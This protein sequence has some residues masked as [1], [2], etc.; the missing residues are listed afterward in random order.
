MRRFSLFSRSAVSAHHRRMPALSLVM[1]ARNEAR[2]IERCLNSVRE[3]VDSMFVLDTGS[4]DGTPEIA[5]RAGARVES[6]TWCDDFSAARNAALQRA[7][8][9]WALVL[10]ADEWLVAGAPALLALRGE[11]PLSIGVLRVDNLFGADAAQAAHSPSWLSRVLPRGVRYEGRIHEQPAADWP[12]RRLDV[13]VLHDGYLDAAMQGKQG[14]NEALLR[15]ALADAPDDLYWHYQ[16]GKDLELRGRYAQALPHYQHAHGGAQR[17]DPW[18]HD[19]VLRLLFTLK[20]L[21]LHAQAMELADAEVSALGDSPDFCF[22][23]GDVLLDWAA[24]DP[25]RGATLVPLIESAW[26][27]AVAIGER[28]ELPDSVQG[29]GSYLAAHN[30]AVLYDGLRDAER[31]RHWRQREQ[32]MRA[33]RPTPEAA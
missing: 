24:H 27:R 22:A 31:S 17:G 29:R 4:T 10:D 14:R 26:K 7:D 21:A 23:L 8:A 5:R 13:T 1:I 20:K 11:P 32:A 16:L 19:L 3:H 30:L 9:D 15:R 33:N 25:A 12:R 18:R 2:C 28:P 6:F